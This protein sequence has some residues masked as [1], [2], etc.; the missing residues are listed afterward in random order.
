M[1][2]TGDNPGRRR[3]PTAAE[4][5]AWRSFIETSELVRTMVASR[6]QAESDLSTG[7]YSVL[8]ALREAAENRMR[9]SALADHIGWERS[10]LS[11]HLGRM[12]RRGLVT[13]EAASGDSRGAEVILNETGAQAFRAASS[14][15]MHAI[16][17]LYVSALSP[18][19]LAAVEEAMGSLRMHLASEKHTRE[20][21]T[22]LPE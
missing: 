10:R 12:E 16:H 11:H 13:R 2:L 9:S 1:T 14:P 6:L 5:R 7:D 3:S 15:H 20:I 8:L 22:S 17:D 18:I 4:L 21:G 19:Q